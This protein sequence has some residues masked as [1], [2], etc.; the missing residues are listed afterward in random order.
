[1][2][3]HKLM[4]LG[5]T[6]SIALAWLPGHSSAQEQAS[7][8]TP[9]DSTL[10]TIGTAWTAD[11]SAVLYYEYHF[12][13]D[14]DLRL[15]THVQYRR[16]DG[17]VFAEK[18]ID[19]S[20]SLTAPEIRH[21]D[22]RNTARITTEFTDDTRPAMIK[23]GFQAHD[24]DRYREEMLSHR[25]SVVVDAGFDPFVRKHWNRLIDGESVSAGMLVPSRLDTIRVSLTKTN[26]RYCDQADVPV[27]CLVIRPA[28]MLRA[29]G[30]LVDP[31]YIG[32]GQQSKL[33]EVF[34]GISNLRDDS[35][36]PQNVLITFDYLQN[37][38]TASLKAGF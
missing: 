10:W 33:L 28:G 25:E 6:L 19:Y 17:S 30:W 24:S 31:I 27:H 32:Y 16:A 5:S 36:D 22:Y 9:D 11:Q 20:R 37:R 38:Q 2:N 21:V 29:V 12:A 14:P 1:M 4:V 34:N 7:F 8:E 35:G 3:M 23:V 15:S 13:E 26:P 18:T